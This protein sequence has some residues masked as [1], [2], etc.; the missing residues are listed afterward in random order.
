VPAL[1]IP[2]RN[3]RRCTAIEG[4][5]EALL[6]RLRPA[7]ELFSAARA[8]FEDLWNQRLAMADAR[9]SS[10]KTELARVERDIEQFLNRIANAQLSSVITACENRIRSIEERK[11]ELN[12]K[13]ANCGRALRSSD[14]TL[15]SSLAFLPSPCNL[16]ASERLEHKRAVLKL[17]F[18]DRLTYVPNEG[19]RTPNLALP[20]KVLADLK[21]S[22]SRM[23][24]PTRIELVFPP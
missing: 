23:A 16:W 15:R 22:K 18:A 2:R 6:H 11:I 8:K 7:L 9:R 4:E 14:E 1:R 13:I 24:L 21:S 5:F 19:F 20:F 10:L 3:I 12:E 17:A